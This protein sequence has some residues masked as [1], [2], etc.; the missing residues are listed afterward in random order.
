MKVYVIF[1]IVLIIVLS[2]IA[3]IIQKMFVYTDSQFLSEQYSSVKVMKI[4]TNYFNYSQQ[5]D[6]YVIVRGNYSQAYQIVNSTA[7]KYLPNSQIITPYDYLNRTRETYLNMINPLVQKV[8]SEILPLHY[9]YK[10]LTLERERIINN[11]TDFIFQ[12]NVTYGIVSGKFKVNN[13]SQVD[14]VVNKFLYIY[15]QLNGT[16]LQK[17][18]NASLI[19]F[20]NPFILLFSFNNFSNYELVRNVI[21]NFSDYPYLVKELTG[22]SVSYE[23]LNNPYNYSLYIVQEKFPPPSVSISNFHKGDEWLFIVRVPANT[24]LVDVKNFMESIKSKNSIVTGHLPIYAESATVTENDL[25]IIDIITVSSLTVL[26]IV[27]LRALI[28]ILL[29]I[30]SAVIGLLISYSLLYLAT[31]LFDYSIYYISGLIIPPIVFGITI[32]YSVLFLYRYY[33]ELRKGNK[34]ALSTAYRSARKAILYSGLSIVLGFSAFVIPPSPLLRNIGVALIISSVSSLIPSIFFLRSVLEGIPIKLLKFPRKEIP[35]PVD[36]RQKYLEVMSRSSIDHKYLV[37]VFV[38]LLG[39]LSYQIFSL[40]Q[41]NVLIEEIVPQTSQ[42][43]VGEKLLTKFFNYSTDYL[44]IEGNPNQTEVFNKVYNVSKE[45]IQEGALVYGPASIGKILINSTGFLTNLYYSH[46]Y[47]LLEVYVPY[48]VFSEGAIDITKKLIS[49]GFLVGGSNAERIDV[50]DNTVNTYYKEVLPLTIIIV[51][52]YLMITL[53][54]VIVPLRLSLTLLVSALFGVALLHL[55]YGSLYWLTPLVVFGIMYSLGIDY[56]M[57]II[58]RILEESGGEEERVIKAVKN[59]GLAVT[60]AGLILATAFLSLLFSNMR[61][62][63][64][65]GLGVGITILF[66]TF[67]V[68]P[69]I[70]PAVLSILKKYNWWPKV[71]S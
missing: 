63:Q 1:W 12:L 30:I 51:T 31:V 32:D 43:V 42:V 4:M 68:R 38:I 44:V 66:D 58:V 52:V 37:L 7:S 20:K 34:N 40:G 17:V 69:I 8:Y 54:S 36:I 65:I 25:R 21:L 28:P 35:N 62:L 16:L 71:R 9:L 64:E 47:T 24:S 45:L 55:L 10:N 61:F 22:K 6:I 15:S 14:G 60:A 19:L 56:D 33:E 11:F 3:L 26:L 27:L 18:R 59:T 46:N 41:I 70:V 13:N 23:A 49:Q 2:P 39:V 48:P 53:G 5:E 29:L 50:V 67:I 57:F